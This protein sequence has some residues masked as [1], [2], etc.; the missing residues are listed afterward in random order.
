[1]DKAILD[2]WKLRLLE[3]IEA[4]AKQDTVFIGGSQWLH[5]LTPEEIYKRGV[6]RGMEIVMDT[7]RNFR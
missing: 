2:Q 6:K 5:E 1:M 4:A 7:A 3:R